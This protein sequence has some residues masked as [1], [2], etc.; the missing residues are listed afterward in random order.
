MILVEL[1]AAIEIKGLEMQDG[2]F[3]TIQEIQLWNGVT[4]PSF[5]VSKYP[6]SRNGGKAVVAADGKPWIVGSC[7][8]AQRACEDVGLDLL[9]ALQHAAIAY[10]I[11]LCK[12]NWTTKRGSPVLRYARGW[13]AL[14]NGERI[15][16]FG[17]SSWVTPS[18]SA[19]DFRVNQ[20]AKTGCFRA[21]ASMGKAP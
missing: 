4:V 15:Y 18:D 16:A 19:L 6:C 21:V 5:R 2:E 9:N 8:E 14:P 3:I 13:F 7:D 17:S 10:S 20:M 1:T 11:G 12:I